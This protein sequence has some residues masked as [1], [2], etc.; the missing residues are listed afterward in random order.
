MKIPWERG[1]LWF[2]E[3][4]PRVSTLVKAVDSSSEC[5]GERTNCLLFLI[6]RDSLLQ[7]ERWQASLKRC[8]YDRL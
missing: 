8:Q 4:F 2:L 5:T 6:K 7:A 1:S 3:H